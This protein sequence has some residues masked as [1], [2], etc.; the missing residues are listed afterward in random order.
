MTVSTNKTSNPSDS[1]TV[2]IDI[3]AKELGIDPATVIE[4]TTLEE[5]DVESLDLIQICFELEEIY[6]I[7]IPYEDSAFVMDSVGD[8]VEVIERLRHAKT[9][10]EALRRVG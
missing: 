2:V 8:V 3:I 6:D 1:S 4:T 9:S 7:E 5:L 10:G